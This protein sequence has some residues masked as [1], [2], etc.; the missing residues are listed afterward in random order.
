MDSIIHYQLNGRSTTI[1][2]NTSILNILT[3]LGLSP[4]MV[5]IEKNRTLI[6]TKSLE[7]TVVTEGDIIEII[8]Y[9]G[10][11][12]SKQY[13]TNKLNQSNNQAYI[14]EPIFN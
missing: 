13:P 12:S 10:G 6:P 14:D 1:E 5:I 3:D 7:S 9:V 8:R 11:G 2:K 4:S